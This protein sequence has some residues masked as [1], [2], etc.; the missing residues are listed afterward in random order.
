MNNETKY[1]CVHKGGIK[2]ST[3]RRT[4]ILDAFVRL[5]SRFGFDKTTMHDIAKEVGISVGV[6]YKDYSNKEDL[7]M[8]YL[9]RLQHEFIING[10]KLFKE[11]L[12]ADELLKA[13]MMYYMT[14]ACRSMIENRG[15]K[16]FIKAEE[17]FRFFKANKAVFEH[18]ITD[19]IA[20]IMEKGVRENVFTINDIQRTAQLFHTAFRSIFAELVLSEDEQEIQAGIHYGEELVEF[21]IKALV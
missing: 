8:E 20:E 5:V 10:R 15:F 7:I 13:F 3:D 21:L 14:T 4:E 2:V 18:K 19:L 9:L 12:Q 16:Q 6:I 11:N 1:S 17:N